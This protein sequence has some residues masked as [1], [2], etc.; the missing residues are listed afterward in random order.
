MIKTFHRPNL[1]RST[2]SIIARAFETFLH[3]SIEEG[4]KNGIQDT[5][6]VMIRAENLLNE[7]R[8]I[9][10]NESDDEVFEL[11]LKDGVNMTYFLL[12]LKLNY[13]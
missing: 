5:S 4:I 6:L 3:A 10:T 13:C 7:M 11:M 8:K 1:S 12:L 2:L 9:I